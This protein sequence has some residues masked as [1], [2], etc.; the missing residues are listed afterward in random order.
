MS[1]ITLFVGTQKGLFRF[2]ANAGRSDWTVDGPHMAG[3]EVIHVC[4]SPLDPA[5][6]YAA[7][8]H[9]VWEIGRAHV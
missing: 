3:Y 6:V 9:T 2:R 1:A 7:V 8:K 5:L 4:A